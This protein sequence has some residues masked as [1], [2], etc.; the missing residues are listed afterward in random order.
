[1]LHLG[2]GGDDPQERRAGVALLSA[3]LT[4][5]TWNQKPWEDR[6]IQV[7]VIPPPEAGLGAVSEKLP[8]D[9]SGFPLESVS[10]QRAEHQ[11]ESFDSPSLEKVGSQR[12]GRSEKEGT[13]GT[14]RVKPGCCEITCVWPDPEREPSE[15]LLLSQ[16]L[17]TVRISLPSR[18]LPV[19]P[20]GVQGPGF[21]SQMDGYVRAEV[22]SDTLVALSRNHFSLVMY[23]LQHHL[24][25]LNLTEESVI[26]TLAKLANG[27]VGLEGTGPQRLP[28][29]P[30]L[31]LCPAM[32]T[33]CETVQF[34]L[35]HLEDS[36]YPVM[37]EDQFALKLFPMY[38]YF[39]TVWLR[40]NTPEV[41][42]GVIK[43]LK[44]MLNLL[45]PR[46]ALRD[47]VYDSLPLLLAGY[48][49]SLEALFITRV[50]SRAPAQQRFS[51]QNLAEIVHSFIAPARSYPKE[52]MQFFLSQM[53]MSKEAIRV[54][55]LALIGQW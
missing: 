9:A 1:M 18:V 32:E 16:G 37:P 19:Q 28:A 30:A 36:V 49:G 10:E 26:V 7:E 52:L 8:Q 41:K 53:E 42:L 22:A 33:F 21:P 31:R 55:T 23:E 12:Q 50:C 34:Y 44:P 13:R 48:Q 35:R 38:R 17:L 39:L 40:N 20:E 3:E 24:K 27:T 2:G 51:S 43:S 45:L 14:A 15:C 46:D 47:Q 6:L 54:G 25:P 29:G 11:I 4:E 5:F